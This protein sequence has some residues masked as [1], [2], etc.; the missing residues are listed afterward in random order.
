MVLGNDEK[1]VLTYL[2]A[3]HG[4]KSEIEPSSSSVKM[5]AIISPNSIVKRSKVLVGAKFCLTSRAM[6]KV[7]K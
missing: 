4:T 1:V 2:S 7:E 6:L 5:K 3:M